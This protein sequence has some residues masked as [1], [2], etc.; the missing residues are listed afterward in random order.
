MLASGAK[1][2]VGDQLHP[3]GKMDETTYRLIGEAYSEV[4]AKEPWCDGVTNVADI[5]VLSSEAETGN[6]GADTGVGRVLLEEPF[7]VRPDR[8]QD[9]FL[10][11]QAADPTGRYTH[12]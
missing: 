9:G 12:R 3:N 4:E 8:S 2:S 10:A 7:P 1:C 6:R 11:V 5:A